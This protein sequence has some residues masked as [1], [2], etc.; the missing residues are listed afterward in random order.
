MDC[1]DTTGRTTVSTSSLWSSTTP[2]CFVEGAC[3]VDAGEEAF[4]DEDLAE[5]AAAVALLLPGKGLVQLLPRQEPFL[6]EELPERAPH[7]GWGRGRFRLGLRRGLDLDAVLLGECARERER[8]ERPGLDEDLAD[9]PAGPLLLG[10]RP[11]ELVLGQQ[12]F[13]HEERSKRLPGIRGIHLSPYR[14]ERGESL[15]SLRESAHGADPHLLPDH[16]HRPLRGVL[17]GARIR[18]ARPAADRRRGGQR[19]HGPARRRRP[20]RAD[21]QLRRRLVRDR[22]GLRPHRG[23]GRRS[24]RDSRA[25]RRPG[26]RARAAAVL[27]PRGRLATVLR[28]RSGRV[29]DRAH[30]ARGT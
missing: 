12:A 11:L 20:A 2:F 8:G 4:R 28:P 23:H 9:E 21:L 15:E 24:R 22:H 13:R 25:P 10:Q 16:R 6:D 18:G 27:G 3:E 17:R 30:R 5:L 1:S 19:L 14:P 29:Q 26:H 7:R